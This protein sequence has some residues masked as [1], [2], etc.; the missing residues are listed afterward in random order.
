[1]SASVSPSGSRNAALLL[2]LMGIMSA[3]DERQRATVLAIAAEPGKTI[4]SP[5]PGG[6]RFIEFAG[7][8]ELENP[9]AGSWP[10]AGFARCSPAPA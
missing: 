6:H 3:S 8:L 1:M 10:A 2:L 9:A 5:V 7:K 4:W